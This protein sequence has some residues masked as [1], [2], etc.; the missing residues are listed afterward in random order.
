MIDWAYPRGGGGL[1]GHPL[2]NSRS[3]IKN[4][5]DDFFFFIWG[6]GRRGYAKNLCFSLVLS[7]IPCFIGIIIGALALS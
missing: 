6:R 7:K 2:P 5:K 1:W 3:K 4:E